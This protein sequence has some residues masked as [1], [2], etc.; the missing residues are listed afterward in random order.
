[1]I[2]Q[3]HRFESIQQSIQQLTQQA[4]QQSNVHVKYAYLII[5]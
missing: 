1:M 2:I 3:V 4:I 5:Q